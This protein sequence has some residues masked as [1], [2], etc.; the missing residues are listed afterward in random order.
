MKTLVAVAASMAL[1]SMGF[2]S[3]QSL[4]MSRVSCLSALSDSTVT[5]VV[6]D[7][8]GYIL[9]DPDRVTVSRKGADGEL[10]LSKGSVETLRFLMANPANYASDRPVYGVFTPSLTY[11]FYGIKGRQLNVC[12]DFS[13]RKFSLVDADGKQIGRYDMADDELLRFSL[14]IYPDDSFLNLILQSRQK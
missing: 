14:G 4:R 5:K 11:R 8:L 13:L 12:C 9:A 10:T 6:G 7:S 1:L 3:C 2:Q